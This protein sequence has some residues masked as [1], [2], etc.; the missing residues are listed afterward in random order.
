MLLTVESQHLA[1]SWHWTCYGW[2][3]RRDSAELGTA[4][5]CKACRW[6]SSLGCQAPDAAG[7]AGEHH[8]ITSLC[9]P[10]WA[11]FTLEVTH[12]M[13]GLKAEG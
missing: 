8:I 6:G 7:E 2:L 13:R 11:G 3:N 4:R 1:H 10:Q 12:S 5:T 9:E